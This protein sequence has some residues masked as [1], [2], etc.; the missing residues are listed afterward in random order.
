MGLFIILSPWFACSRNWA[1][2]GGGIGPGLTGDSL[3]QWSTPRPDLFPVLVIALALTS[4]AVVLT[5]GAG[6]DLRLMAVA[7]LA[8]LGCTV[9]VD[10]AA[11]W[12][13]RPE[14]ALERALWAIYLEE[15]PRAVM[16]GL[17][18]VEL[19]GR[20]G[21]CLRVA[22]RCLYQAGRCRRVERGMRRE[23]ARW[24]GRAR[25]EMG[26]GPGAFGREVPDDEETLR[27]RRAH[28][29]RPC[30]DCTID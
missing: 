6:D 15:E 24:V 30:W 10:E 13:G 27:G 14:R 26:R 3:C 23:A 7:L 12:W 21:M 9:A 19:P 8:G 11:R 22:M 1:Y 20:A 16:R 17:E 5:P 28:A 4:L 29:R 2:K 18:G 25:E